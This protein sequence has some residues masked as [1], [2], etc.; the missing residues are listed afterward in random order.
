MEKEIAKNLNYVSDENTYQAI[1]KYLEDKSLTQVGAKDML[2]ELKE[3]REIYA[4]NGVTYINKAY[5][6]KLDNV[7]FFVL[8]KKWIGFLDTY[9]AD[10]LE[11]SESDINLK[12][13]VTLTEQDVKG[14]EE[15]NLYEC[16][17]I[18][19]AFDIATKYDPM[20]SRGVDGHYETRF[21]IDK[22]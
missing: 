9:S 7:R 16:M 19:N 21:V 17:M 20:R 4:K 6:K 22:E 15:I 1:V 13:D 12:K 10:I 14:L 8:I 3:D 2:R 5:F 11:L 18:I